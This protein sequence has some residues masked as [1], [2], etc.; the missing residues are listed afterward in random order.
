MNAHSVIFLADGARI[1][2]TGEETYDSSVSSAAGKSS[3]SEII[4]ASLDA[5][6]FL[7]LAKASNVEGE[8]GPTRFSIKGKKLESWQELAEKIGQ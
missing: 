4:I 5:A 3:I 2:P 1:H 8:L 6:D 7:K